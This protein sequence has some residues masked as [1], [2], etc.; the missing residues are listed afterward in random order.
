LV[1]A[2][3]TT[4]AN[5]RPSK[6]LSRA[7]SPLPPP[8]DDRNWIKV[9]SLEALER[10]CEE[11]HIHDAHY[12]YDTGVLSWDP[13]VMAEG[14]RHGLAC[15]RIISQLD[16]YAQRSRPGVT[17]SYGSS[18]GTGRIQVG[19]D[20]QGRRD[21]RCPDAGFRAR[22]RPPNTQ[23]SH[24]FVAEVASS[25]STPAVL[26]KVRNVWF[27][28]NLSI[29]SA[30]VVVFEYRAPPPQP[31]VNNQRQPLR[32]SDRL[33]ALGTGAGPVAPAGDGLA[34]SPRWMDV[35]FLRKAN[36]PNANPQPVLRVGTGPGRT[37]ANQVA[38]ADW[39]LVIPREAVGL[40]NDCEALVLNLRAVWDEVTSFI[41]GQ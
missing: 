2:P 41:P 34:T 16:Q 38:A 17:T 1:S 3:T 24:T 23:S 31:P 36:Q 20:A 11:W 8:P 14:E 6:A 29:L 10:Y 28:P 18:T 19:V 4:P 5:K 27:L 12:D 37:P 35:Y 9:G 39:R 25:Q 7:A 33:A 21:Y 26:A 40:H 13:D 32:R 15:A 22:D 30:L